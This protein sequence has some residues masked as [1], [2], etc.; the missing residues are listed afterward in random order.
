M[1]TE[2]LQNCPLQHELLDLNLEKS[3]TVCNYAST[4]QAPAEHWLAIFDEPQHQPEECKAC[5]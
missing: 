3:R 1:P 4:W 2:S 5:L